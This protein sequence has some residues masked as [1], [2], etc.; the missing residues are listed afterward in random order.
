VRK[1]HWKGGTLW[2]L[3]GLVLKTYNV[4]L[5]MLDVRS[6]E[7]VKSGG[8][9]LTHSLHKEGYREATPLVCTD[10]LRDGSVVSV[11]DPLWQAVCM[12]FA[13]RT[14]GAGLISHAGTE[15]HGRLNRSLYEAIAERST[16]LMGKTQKESNLRS[17]I[18]LTLNDPSSSTTALVIGVVI[19][20]LIVMST[21]TFCLETLPWWGCTS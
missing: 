2:D 4:P 17:V 13:H 8:F 20:V 11:R 12:I 6:K 18:D 3:L 14:H 10:G 9:V 19:L 7:G 5:E 16:E 21:I 15:P 1:V